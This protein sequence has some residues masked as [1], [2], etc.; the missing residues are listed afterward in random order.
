VLISMHWGL[1]AALAEGEMEIGGARRCS[2]TQH[3]TTRYPH[4]CIAG[5]QSY[6]KV[7]TNIQAPEIPDLRYQMDEEEFIRL[8]HWVNLPMTKVV[9]SCHT[10]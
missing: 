3:A 5:R 9:A 2:C 6:E 7:N 4:R 1:D 10:H 8:P